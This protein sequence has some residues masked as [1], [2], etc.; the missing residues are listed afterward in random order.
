M[1]RI[2]IGVLAA[3]L[4]SAVHAASGGS[5]FNIDLN[6]TR[7]PGEVQNSAQSSNYTFV[8]GDLDLETNSP[9]FSYKFNPVAQNAIGIKDE[10]YI[11]VPEAFVQP[12]LGSGFNLAIGR[13]KR[14]WSR[15]DEE[16]NLGIWQPQLR[17]D[18]LAPKQEGLIGVFFDIELSEEFRL[19]FLFSPLFLPDQGPNYQLTNGRFSSRN[20]WFSQP[21]SR[22]ALFSESG[23]NPS[24]PL[25]FEIDRP[26]EEQIIM[27]S[28]F[29]FALNY[30]S[31]SQFW[32][33]ASYAYKPQNQ[34]HLGIE[35]ATCLSIVGPLE[36]TAII[37]PAVIMHHVATLESGYD[38]L[39]YRGYLS[40]TG[41]FPSESKFPQ[42][43]AES[44]LDSM[45]IAGG[46]FQHVLFH[47][48]GNPSTLKYSY[49][50]VFNVKTRDKK[51]LVDAEQVHSS[52]DRY[53]Y[54]EVAAA[55][56]K[57][58]LLQTG[59]NRLNFKAR[60]SYSVPEKGGWISAG[61]DLNQGPLTWYAGADV[62]GS[63]VGD[64]S[65]NAGLFT[66]YRS[67]DRAFGG[68]SYVF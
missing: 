50:R 29:G 57:L 38:G 65:P 31:S 56:W 36:I 6:Q 30:Q 62:L 61:L 64:D 54:R 8:S 2:L 48:M 59:A 49:I 51:G 66:K 4:G 45:M 9:G 33:S 24:T 3:T 63:G 18:Y 1:M 16:F 37:H 7:Y 53:P 25:Y 44:P 11:G 43:Y 17:W 60:Y 13:Q 21:Q 27:H 15:L 12:R 68:V 26:A 42:A 58:T 10:F 52:L 5:Y 14:T 22:V 40:L 47:W 23:V 41:D 35:C 46:G 67:N 19:T 39:N 20:R 28:S 34:L 32:T 55:E